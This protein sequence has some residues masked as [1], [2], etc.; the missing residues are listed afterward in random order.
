M[1]CSGKGAWHTKGGFRTLPSIR[2]DDENRR[3]KKPPESGGYVAPEDVQPRL[4]RIPAD[5]W[6]Y[7]QR[8]ERL[9]RRMEGNHQI[10]VRPE[11]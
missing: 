2:D 7:G 10:A 1:C 8:I 4:S 9:F 11:M 3:Q 5:V 6:R